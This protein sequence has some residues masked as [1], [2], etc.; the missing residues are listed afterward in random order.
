[1]AMCTCAD[2]LNSKYRDL[3]IFLLKLGSERQN[4]N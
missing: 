2:V 4:L 1:M 3:K